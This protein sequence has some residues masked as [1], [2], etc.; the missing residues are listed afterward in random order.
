MLSLSCISLELEIH[1]VFRAREQVL[2]T[3]IMKRRDRLSFCGARHFESKC[4]IVN[5][6]NTISK[7]STFHY[8]ETIIILLFVVILLLLLITVLCY[9]INITIN[10]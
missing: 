6:Y 4:Y 9:F 5:S 8:L 1:D 7:E 3:L 10:N 2:C